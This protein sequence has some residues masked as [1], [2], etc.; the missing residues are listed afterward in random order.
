MKRGLTT[1]AHIA[2]IPDGNRRWSK[3]HKLKVFAGYRMGIRRFIDF[4]KWSKEFGVKTLTVWALST[5][6]LRNRSGLELKV[7]FDLYM[8]VATD[9]SIL[10]DL[11]ANGA[12]LRVIGDM[13][14][15]PKKLRDAFRNVEAQTKMYKDMTINL[16]VNY[17]GK[18]DILYSMQQ[19]S[20]D[21]KSN[22]VTKVDQKYI[23]EH[24]RSATLPDVDLIVRTSG[25]MRTSGLLP[26]QGSY[27]ELYFSNKY[28]PDFGR[29]DFR[30]AIQT[31]SKRQRR[32][33][34]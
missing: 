9:K 10:R 32:F 19:M 18:D 3:L 34:K 25:E 7:L 33:G 22:K 21:I 30:K 11:K 15:L 28:W 4:T 5:E 16:L 13:N 23:R 17:G 14:A 29:E 2:L 8:K 20:R 24:L 26:W 27:S 6:N 1:P 12:R 31:F